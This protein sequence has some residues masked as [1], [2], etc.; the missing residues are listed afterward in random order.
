MVRMQRLHVSCHALQSLEV[1]VLGAADE[2]LELLRCVKHLEHR[3][4]EQAEEAALEGVDLLL[5][6]PEGEAVNIPVD[7]VL[8]VV[9]RH[10][11]LVPVSNQVLGNRL[12]KG[13]ELDD[14]CSLQHVLQRRLLLIVQNVVETVGEL[15]VPHPQIVN[16]RL[17]VEQD[18]VADWCDRN[19]K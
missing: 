11:D 4:V 3:L 2:V 15:R 12:A 6:L 1:K 18:F 16:V 7:K 10:E 9:F 17:L 13:R 5:A 14:E 8:A 19:I